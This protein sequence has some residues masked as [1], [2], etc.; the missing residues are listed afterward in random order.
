MAKRDKKN[1]KFI[2]KLRIA[3]KAKGTKQNYVSSLR[4][5][6]KYCVCHDLWPFDMPIETDLAMFWI[7]ERVQQAG[8]IK[9]LT[10][11]T[12]TLGWICELK[13]ADVVYNKTAEWKNFIKS[14]KKMY[15]EEEDKRLPFKLEH[16]DN[17]TKYHKAYGSNFK[18]LN[19]NIFTKI[20]IAQ[21]YFCCMPRPCEIVQVKGSSS[22]LGIRFKHIKLIN[23]DDDANKWYFKFMF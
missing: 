23:E 21:I 12:A 7:A 16:I 15:E 8:S 18:N 17:Y 9:S 19:M 13:T 20:L 2:A 4:H 11:W 5:F 6:T 14:L 3:T 1:A 22:K 10:T